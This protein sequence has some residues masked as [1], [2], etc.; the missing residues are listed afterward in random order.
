MQIGPINH[1]PTLLPFPSLVPLLSTWYLVLM[2]ELLAGVHNSPE[3]LTGVGQ[4]INI[5]CHW[6]YSCRGTSTFVGIKS[7]VVI[8]LLPSNY[9]FFIIRFMFCSV[10]PLICFL[11]AL[12]WLFR[13]FSCPPCV[14]YLKIADPFSLPINRITQQWYDSSRFQKNIH[15]ACR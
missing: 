15:I 3:L 1:T 10:L 9:L 5:K 8:E 12:L 7:V 4:L 2:G 13:S 14:I 6:H 11:C